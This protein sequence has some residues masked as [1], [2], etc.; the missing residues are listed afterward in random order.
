MLFDDRRSVPVPPLTSRGCW[1]RRLRRLTA[2]LL[3]LTVF[4]AW[5]WVGRDPLL[6]SAADFWIVSDSV[7]HADAAVV[8]GGGLGT[9]PFEAAEL[10]KKGLVNKV[11]IS[12][13]E[14]D[15]A[16]AIGVVQGYTES[17]RQVLLKL[18]V[19]AN[20]IE[21]F[22]KA[23]KNTREEA[24]ALREWAERHATLDLIIPTEEF[25]TR[26][27]RWIFHREFAG[28]A[29][30]IKVSS[31]ETTL[32]RRGEWWKTEQG[33]LIFQNEVLKYIYYRI[34]Y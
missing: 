34:K 17:N 5:A 16:V 31:F 25:T 19:P 22:G 28:H 10:Y 26:R 14:E 11:L 9:R 7:T 18:G 4:G 32:V 33:M 1:I 23:N 3:V 21:T 27:V 13:V 30:R 29:G 24:L 20:A 2:V 6:R 15:R 12:Q 8:L